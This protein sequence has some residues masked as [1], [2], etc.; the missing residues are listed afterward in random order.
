MLPVGEVLKNV[1]KNMVKITV[2]FGA[3]QGCGTCEVLCP[4]VFQIR[5]E[6]SWVLKEDGNENCSLEEVV[7][8]CPTEAIKVEGMDIKFVR[9]A[10]F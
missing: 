5:D 10:P 1:G 8:S 2:D 6:K 4:D 3:C 9:K 7:Q